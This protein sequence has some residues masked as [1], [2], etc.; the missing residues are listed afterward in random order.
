MKENSENLNVA[1]A[2]KVQNRRRGL[3]EGSPKVCAFPSRLATE[4][5]TAKATAKKMKIPFVDPLSTHIEPAAVALLDRD[6]ASRREALPIRFVDDILVVAMATPEQP[7]A[8]RSLELLTGHKIRPVAA[9]RSSIAKALQE[10]Y[11][12]PAT[13]TTKKGQVGSK[14]KETTPPQEDGARALTVSIISNKG[15]VGKTHLSINLAH[16]LAN[17]GA[18]VLLIDADLGNA[19]ISNKLGIFPEHH[20]LDFLDKNQQMQDLVVTTQFNFD[21]ICGTYGEFK[22]ANLNYAQKMKFIK[23]FQKISRAYDF[24]VFDLGA[25]IART[26]LDF[27]LGADRTVIVTTPQDVISGYACA[28]AVFSRFKEIEERL[29]GRLS[30]YTPQWTFSP[31]LVINQVANLEQG[32]KLYDTIEKTADKNINANEGRFCLKPEYLGAIPYDREKLRMTEANKRPLLVDSPYIKASQCIQH[33]ST[34]FCNTENPYDPRVN[35]RHPLK[36]F[37]AILSQKI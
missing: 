36:R 31:M 28:K 7:I 10:V 3:S 1:K 14:T 18:R 2:T 37:V 21:L 32:F 5:Q 33:M 19:D 17:T 20:L 22:L 34:R 35:F 24:A 16:A 8:I 15:G 26:V 11:S 30:E 6:I 27:A 4:T 25:G 23:H 13:G 12:Q 9:P 29:E